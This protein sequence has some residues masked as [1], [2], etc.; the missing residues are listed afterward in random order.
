[1]KKIAL[2][3]HDRM[4]PG[5]STFI[6]ERE[7]WLWGKSLVATGRTA[8][9]LKQD[10]FKVPMIHLSPGRSGG[11]LEI[12]EMIKKGEV[13][14]VLFFRDPQVKEHDHPDITALMDVC[15]AQ[16]VPLALNAA[17]A[18]MLILGLIRLEATRK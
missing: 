2:L 12:T 16:N 5:L 17:S 8:E 15:L 7:D 6:R 10:N 3:A 18:E 11:Y 4:K 1:M 14:L 9:F 13:Q